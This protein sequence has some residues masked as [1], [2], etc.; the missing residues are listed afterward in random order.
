MFIGEST[1]LQ[2]RQSPLLIAYKSS[3]P[4][5]DVFMDMTINTLNA[6][7][8]DMASSSDENDRIR[9]LGLY[10]EEMN[11]FGRILRT[12]KLDKI[13]DFASDVR[14]YG[15]RS[16]VNS[17]IQG[18]S[19]PCSISCK[20]INPP[21]Y[22]SFHIVFPIEFADGAKWMLKIPAK[23]DHFDSV[24]AAALASEAR[25]MQMLRRET[26]IPVPIVYAFDTSSNNDLLT[27]F[28]LMEKLDGRPLYHLWFDSEVPKARLEHFRIKALQSLA[29]AMVQ[30]NKF[31]L[32]TGGSLVFNPDGTPVGL[33][34]AKVV[35]G[36]AIFNKARASQV[37]QTTSDKGDE[38]N[39]D[40]LR[41]EAA[42][43]S[44]LNAFGCS[45]INADKSDDDDIIY[46][47][48]P[49][50]NPK[51]Y[52]MSNLDRSDPAFR[53]DA[54]ERGTDRS[55][56]LFIEWAFADSRDH[57][58]RFVLAHPDLDVQNILVAEDGTLTGLIDWDGVAA[59]P[60]EVGCAQYP[61]WLMRDWVPLR[62]EYDI[63]KGRA[64]TRAGYEESSPAE[65]ASYRALYAHLM[66]V[67]IEKMTGG[68]NKRT[69]FGTSP[70]QEA[71]LTRR[72][73]IM[74]NLDLSAGDPW[75]ALGTVNHIIDQ[76]E[77]LTAPGWED[78]DSISSFSSGCDSD[79]DSSRSVDSSIKEED[80]EP[81]AP[82]T[83]EQ[84]SIG[85]RVSVSAHGA[86]QESKEM[87][88]TVPEV[89]V[90]VI[91]N[92]WGAGAQDRVFPAPLG[93][94][95]TDV[96]KSK[97]HKASKVDPEEDCS[98]TS[99]HLGW[100]RRLL[101][102]GC[103]TAEKSLRKLAKI[104]Y[105][106][107]IAVDEAA[108]L[109][110]EAGVQSAVTVAE[111]NTGKVGELD[112]PQ[113]INAIELSEEM[114]TK[115]L[116][117]TL[118]TN[119]TRGPEQL[120]DVGSIG[121]TADVQKIPSTQTVII[122]DRIKRSASIPP[123]VEPQ[124]I[125]L[126]KA[127][128]LQAARAV[129]KAE[130]K[131]HYLADKAAIKKELKVW[132]NIALAVWRRGIS[133]EQLQLN[134][135]KIASSVVDMI[136]SEQEHE[137]GLAV[138]THLP[139]ATEV[140]AAAAEMVDSSAAALSRLEDNSM[141]SK[142]EPEEV[143][144]E[145]DVPQTAKVNGDEPSRTSK[146][147]ITGVAENSRLES[148][149]H[150]ISMKISN[151]TCQAIR[152]P[153]NTVFE[154]FEDNKDESE[155]PNANLSTP[156]PQA[157]LCLARNS[158][159]SKSNGSKKRTKKPT[160]AK[161]DKTSPALGKENPSSSE[162]SAFNTLPNNPVSTN[163]PEVPPEEDDFA[164]A[165]NIGQKNKMLHEEAARD[166]TKVR[167]SQTSSGSSSTSRECVLPAAAKTS[168]SLRALCKFGTS[169]FTQILFNRNQSK[170]D[171][172]CLSQ[173]SSVISESGNE[174]EGGSDVED[175]H[176]SAT[177]LSDD[178]VNDEENHEI[179][180]DKD[181]TPE[182]AVIATNEGNGGGCGGDEDGE[183]FDEEGREEGRINEA[184]GQTNHHKHAS[185][186]KGSREEDGLIKP[187]A[188]RRTYDPC[189]EDWVEAKN[190]DKPTKVGSTTTTSDKA[191]LAEMIDDDDG[192]DE[193]DANIESGH[194]DQAGG[195]EGVESLGDSGIPEFEDH[196]GFDR[197][198]VCNLLGMG[199]LDELRLLRL[200]EGFLM[201]LEQY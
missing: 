49:F 109:S 22:G 189:T 30:L 18:L 134:Q 135:G 83:D 14:Q 13:P 95:Q 85:M 122:S 163:Q 92:S 115:Q 9:M 36:V 2:P 31:T 201:L 72:S 158:R 17:P 107:E 41:V 7:V 96:G 105:A 39:P 168:Y 193:G 175:T 152:A 187:C 149:A 128:L 24:A 27:P 11:L 170:E 150:R 20:V 133:L 112:T 186:A 45:Q 87:E 97:T 106:L 32:N 43:S 177:S 78:T 1:L 91:N 64:C 50:S 117:D 35:D 118:S 69:T 54:Y 126:R 127:E 119:D 141:Q 21:L 100:T 120:N 46:E 48:G 58:R 154:I 171:K 136:R 98:T 75:V 71:D 81:Q 146:V 103:N 144:L 90:K 192:G 37:H 153:E 139:S 102:F 165:F 179:K 123:T 62:Y 28:I 188:S 169:Y 162:R 110:S 196:G 140:T 70:K 108:E 130:R 197:Y 8:S 55:L 195:D 73:L 26:S 157:G 111:E 113:Q 160:T 47:R 44:T 79:S 155:S 52:F 147:T 124:D 51:E 12:M 19:E 116:K 3:E 67:E 15:H 93:A 164:V 61:L 166:F 57:D 173:E 194:E 6:N 142:G 33:G 65:L 34:G 82:E 94:S 66:E 86:D 184:M 159:T 60:R 200:K 198:T 178:Q 167:E 99:A 76:I 101:R 23:G 148:K 104:G 63:D 181:D 190:F 151:T 56:R 191:R 5:I 121:S 132:E 16:T 161:G 145:E 172:E 68:S 53:A 84:G 182:F 185:F 42:K 138:S 183:E 77:E 174:E 131:A 156:Q 29:G 143:R 25:T 199:E 89:T 74:R 59:V 180:E 40:D 125:L 10:E 38:S 176:S 88:F 80:T 137:D 114:G 129:K 4:C